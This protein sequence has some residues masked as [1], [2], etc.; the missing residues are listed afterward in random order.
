MPTEPRR[1]TL[2][3]DR[4]VKAALELVDR[5]GID[6]L[7]MRRLG[8]ELGVEGMALYTHVRGKADL[9]DAVAERIVGEL[10]VDFDR[11]LPWQGRIRRAALAWA[12]LQARHPRGFPL[13]YRT[14][15]S[16]AAVQQ[17]TEEMLDAL[18]TAGLEAR[19]AVLAYQTVVILIDSA[20]LA[21]GGTTDRARQAAWR[22]AA[23]AT[24]PGSFPRFA[25]AAPQ[26]AT[27]TWRDI[28]DSSL[29]LLVA[30]LEQRVRS[31][32]RPDSRAGPPRSS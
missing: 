24:D 16:S 21:V 13:V 2:S 31:T 23:K 26:A 29:D 15:Y 8:G 30:G 1:R 25:E 3:R 7:S 20:L 14:G 28:L 9:L 17:L 32:P 4:V 22:R 18:R 6:A 12:G 5:E 10:D 11:S 27:L 19:A